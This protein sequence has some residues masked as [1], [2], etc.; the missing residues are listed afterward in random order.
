VQYWTLGFFIERFDVDDSA[1]AG[2]HQYRDLPIAG[3]YAQKSFH[4][5]RIALLDNDV[6]SIKKSV[7]GVDCEPGL[8]HVDR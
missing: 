7:N 4:L 2:C 1:I 3:A 8:E 6:K 5:E